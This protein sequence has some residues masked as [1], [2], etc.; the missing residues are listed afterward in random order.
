MLHKFCCTLRKEGHG[1]LDEPPHQNWTACPSESSSM[2]QTCDSHT[3]RDRDCKGGWSRTLQPKWRM[4]SRVMRVCIIMEH[5]HTPGQF[6][7]YYWQFAACVYVSLEQPLYIN[8]QYSENR[9]DTLRQKTCHSFMMNC[10][11]YRHARCQC[12]AV[13]FY[14]NLKFHNCL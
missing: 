4:V 6:S 1:L 8:M 9:H 12:L 14:I 2:A 11:I 7:S 3:G 10:I 13:H 5:K